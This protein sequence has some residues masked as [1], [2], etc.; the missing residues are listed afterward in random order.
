M[1]IKD[2]EHPL[3]AS[4]VH[5]EAYHMVEKMATDLGVEISSLIGN[6]E[7]VNDIDPKKYVTEQFG[8]HTMKDILSS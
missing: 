5:P 4:A 1:R 3:D 8:L 6:E 2:G 7:L